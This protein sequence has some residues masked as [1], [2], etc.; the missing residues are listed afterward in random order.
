MHVSDDRRFSLAANDET[1]ESAI[2]A[3]QVSL[4]VYCNTLN[5]YSK[6]QLSALFVIIH[7]YDTMHSTE[8]DISM[9]VRL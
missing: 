8:A 7:R 6:A 2:V 1:A 3:M 9:S 4:S 5:L